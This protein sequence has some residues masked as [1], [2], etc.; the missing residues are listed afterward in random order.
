MERCDTGGEL[1]HRRKDQLGQDVET[2]AAAGRL[3]RARVVAAL[4]GSCEG[5]QKRRHQVRVGL[6]Q[7]HAMAEIELVEAQRQSAQAKENGRVLVGI[8]VQRRGKP[9]LLR[10]AGQGATIQP[11]R[12]PMTSRRQMIYASL[13]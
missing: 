13:S 2:E 12:Q 8:I 1:R 6:L 11:C 7:F 9:L 4:D 10:G 5:H 3:Q